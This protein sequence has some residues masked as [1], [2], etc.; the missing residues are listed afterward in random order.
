MYVWVQNAATL[1]WYSS[2]GVGSASR[3]ASGVWVKK[4]GNTVTWSNLTNGIY[5]VYFLTSSTWN[6]ANIKKTMAIDVNAGNATAAYP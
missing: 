6:A 1:T 5:N 4:N 2:A 3:P